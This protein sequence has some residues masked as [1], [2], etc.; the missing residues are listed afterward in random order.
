MITLDNVSKA[1]AMTGGRKIVLQNAT[2]DFAS[3]HNYGVLGANGAGKSTLIRLLAGSEMPDR[4]RIR[5]D[6]RVSFPLGFGGTFHGSLSGRENVA[7]IARVYGASVRHTT[8]YVE[9]FAEL[10]GYFEM[11]VNTY[12]SGMRARLAFGACL[13]VQFE[14]YLIDEVTEIGDE[15]FQQ[16]CAR[17]FR[18]RMQRSD[19][20]LV[21]HN[22]RTIRQYCDRGAVLAR[23][24]LE[25][26]DD[27]DEALA[28]YQ[29]LLKEPV[30]CASEHS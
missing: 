7:F 16:K 18:D 10:G 19:I 9:E 25:L 2:A 1:Y 14:T 28:Q 29:Q 13:A 11:P 5:R 23:G 21:T 12:S 17:A 8:R 24:R 20:I 3:G 27:V 15:R 26:Y 6:A 4:G 30:P 22:S